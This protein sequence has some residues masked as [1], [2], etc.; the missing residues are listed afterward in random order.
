MAFKETVAAIDAYEQRTGRRWPT[1]L[2]LGALAALVSWGT[3]I[4]AVVSLPE[5]S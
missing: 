4:V 3:L 5:R 1:Y 2:L